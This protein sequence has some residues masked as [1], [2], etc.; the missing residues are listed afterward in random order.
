MSKSREPFEKLNCSI[1]KPDSVLKTK[2]ANKHNSERQLN[3][4]ER[5]VSETKPSLVFDYPQSRETVLGVTRKIE[6]LNFES[7]YVSETRCN[8]ALINSLHTT[9]ALD[10][11]HAG[12]VLQLG[13]RNSNSFN[14]DSQMRNSVIATNES[15]WQTYLDRQGRN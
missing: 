3:V 12:T 1:L 9:N 15:E 5:E 11:A 4:N 8:D 7:K 6:L 13:E 14:P 10:V 2:S